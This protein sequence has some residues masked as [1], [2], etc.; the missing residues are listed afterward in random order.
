M[1]KVRK[2]IEDA[3]IAGDLFM[4]RLEPLFCDPLI[5]IPGSPIKE[6]SAGS[7]GIVLG[8]RK[9]SKKSTTDLVKYDVFVFDNFSQTPI[10]AWLFEEEMKHVK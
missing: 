6:I 1:Q 4:I 5:T 9:G 3:F 7:L 8:K 10:V 2:N